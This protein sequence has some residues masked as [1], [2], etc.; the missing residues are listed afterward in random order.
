M[1]PTIRCTMPANEGNHPAPSMFDTLPPETIT[2]IMEELDWYSLMN[3]RKTCRYLHDISRSLTVWQRQLRQYIGRHKQSARLEA[4]LDTFS[5]PELEEWVTR[6]VSADAGWESAHRR[7]TGIRKITRGMTRAYL[8]PGGRWL[9]IGTGDGSLL[10]YD[11]DA[12]G[13]QG[14]LLLQIPS[15]RKI[16]SMCISIDTESPTFG[17]KI[18][19]SS[20]NRFCRA[21]P[22][23]HMAPDLTDICT[24]ATVPNDTFHIWAVTM[25]GRGHEAYLQAKA[26]QLFEVPSTSSQVFNT[27]LL[28]DLVARIMHSGDG[29]CHIDI[30]NWRSSSS[31]AL[32]KQVISLRK[33]I[34]E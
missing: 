21:F 32:C 33:T 31:T 8:V 28:N 20:N 6:R 26:L 18:A 23:E 12:P 34:V 1:A 17:F 15:S 24:F 22:F 9:L 13:V 7:P 10:A 14:R 29:T 25:I 30:F 3:V 11:L 27:T 2:E 19:V 16:E 4:P 5:A